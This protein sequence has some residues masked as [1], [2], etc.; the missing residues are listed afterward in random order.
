MEMI[1]RM[2][3]ATEAINE[4]VA[5][6]SRP[7]GLFI[8]APSRGGAGAGGRLSANP[9]HSAEKTVCRVA[10]KQGEQL[11]TVGPGSGAHSI[12]TDGHRED[13]ALSIRGNYDTA[14]LKCQSEVKR[15]NGGSKAEAPD[16]SRPVLLFIL[17]LMNGDSTTK[18]L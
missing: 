18:D 3:E 14:I 2:S 16:L 17:P 6:K 13:F 9:C 7:S 8:S 1:A 10:G 12:P 5:Q 11:S 15:G 4:I